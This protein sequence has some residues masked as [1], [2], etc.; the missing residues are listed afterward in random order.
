MPEAYVYITLPGA[1]AAVTAGRFEHTVSRNGVAVGRFVYGRRY[2]ERQDAVEID[3]V[4]LRL[5]RAGFET[6]R[7][8]GVFG[9]LRDAGPDYWGR[10][11]IEK[12]AGLARLGELDYLLYAPDDRAGALGFGLGVDPPALVRAFN[13]T[14]DLEKLQSLADALLADEPPQDAAQVEELLLL[15]TSMGGARPK[16]V[17]EH[18]DALW[19]AKFNRP[20]DRWNMAR[21][22]HATLELARRCGLQVAV[23]QIA[24]V[25]GR[26]VL[27]VKRF[28]RERVEGGYSRAR[29]VSALTLLETDETPDGRARW[30]YI[31]LAE[32]LRRISERPREDAHELFRR[33]TFNALVSNID[34]HPRNHAAFAP[35]LGWRLSPAYDLTPTPAVAEERRDLA[36][37]CGRQGRLANAANLLS[38]CRRFLLTPEEASAIVDEMERIVGQEWYAVARGCGIS[39]G[40]CETIRRAYVYP[41][42]RH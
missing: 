11:V 4:E 35:A 30:S 23:S 33:M 42:F 39:E 26:D 9:A 14:W 19:L 25:G 40:D 6:V 16:V 37:A 32:T 18:E 7:L 29:M 24:A 22:E 17:V 15:G 31:L 36:M 3:P 8:N 13:R 34:D 2:R 1:V 41:G 21:V 27:L 5:G 20:D 10:R 28:D 38:E 12:H